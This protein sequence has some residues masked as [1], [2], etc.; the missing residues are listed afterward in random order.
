MRFPLLNAQIILLNARKTFE[1]IYR[2]KKLSV[3]IKS[4]LINHF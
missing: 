1:K 4:N 2:D 3:F